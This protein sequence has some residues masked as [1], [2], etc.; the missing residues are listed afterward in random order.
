MLFRSDHHAIPTLLPP[1]SSPGEVPSDLSHAT[2]IE[3]LQVLGEAENVKVFDYEPLDASRIGTLD[4]P[5]KVFSWV[6]RNLVCFLCFSLS[7]Y[8]SGVL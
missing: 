2:G 3:R 4:D 1:G 5:I 8:A 7:L 6:S